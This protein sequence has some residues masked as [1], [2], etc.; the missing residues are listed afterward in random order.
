[1]NLLELIIARVVHGLFRRLRCR[2]CGQCRD[3]C[4]YPELSHLLTFRSSID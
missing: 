3:H 4:E 1:V 2:A